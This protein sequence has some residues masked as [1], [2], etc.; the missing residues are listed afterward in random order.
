MQNSSLQE[1]IVSVGLEN[2]HA[3]SYYYKN[4]PDLEYRIELDRYI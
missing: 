3:K 4:I 1:D 2:Y